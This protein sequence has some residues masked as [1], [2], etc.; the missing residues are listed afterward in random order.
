LA[1]QK[2]ADSLSGPAG[3]PGRNAADRLNEVYRERFSQRESVASELRQE[4]IDIERLRQ[5]NMAGLENLRATRQALGAL[6]TDISTKN[7]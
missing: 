4:T 3:E 2:L 5:N 7:N 1:I 6:L